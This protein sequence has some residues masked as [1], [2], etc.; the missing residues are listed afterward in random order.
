[1]HDYLVKGGKS[2]YGRFCSEEYIVRPMAVVTRGICKMDAD[3]QSD[4][5]C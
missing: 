5:G 2:V 3:K 4:R 1:M